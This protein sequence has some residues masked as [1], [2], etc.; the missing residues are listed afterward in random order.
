MILLNFLYNGKIILNAK[1]LEKIEPLFYQLYFEDKGEV[2]NKIKKIISLD[3]ENLVF[4]SDFSKNYLKV[5][6]YEFVKNN[7]LTSKPLLNISNHL[8]NKNN[9]YS[10]YTLNNFDILNKNFHL[11]SFSQDFNFVRD[12]IIKLQNKNLIDEKCIIELP[13]LIN[14][15]IFRD[16]GSGDFSVNIFLTKINC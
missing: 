12:I 6:E 1:D 2:K 14:E 15:P 5:Y 13:H 11:V 9:A 3:K 8:N 10:Q 16:S 4:F 7:F